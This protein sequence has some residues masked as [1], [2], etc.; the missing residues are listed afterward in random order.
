MIQRLNNIFEKKMVKYLSKLT[1]RYIIAGK[2]S[3]GGRNMLGRVCVFGRGG[4]NKKLYRFI[5]FYR[6]LNCYG[7]IYRSLY[8]PNRTARISFVLFGNGLTSCLL[9]MEGLRRFSKIYCGS[10]NEVCNDVSLNGYSLTLR[11]IG[12]FNVVSNVESK[13]F[14]GGSICRA[15]GSSCVLLGKDKFKGILKL[16]SG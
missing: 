15:G 4:G 10:G 14:Y 12:S 13:P 7:I 2:V 9:K 16:R 3:N 11:N 5:D 6:R 8:D 1:F